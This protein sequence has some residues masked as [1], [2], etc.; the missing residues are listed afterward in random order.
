MNRVLYSLFLSLNLKEN[1][2][3]FIFQTKNKY[4]RNNE[5]K[6]LCKNYYLF[7]KVYY[8]ILKYG[9]KF[10]TLKKISNNLNAFTKT[11]CTYWL[12][13]A[14]VSISI[15]CTSFIFSLLFNSKEKHLN[16][17]KF[18][19]ILREYI[20]NNKVKKKK[21]YKNSFSKIIIQY[22]IQDISVPS[23][24]K[25]IF[26]IS[27]YKF[28]L[29]YTNTNSLYLRKFLPNN[30][31]A[32]TGKTEWEGRVSPANLTSKCF[33][34][35]G[36]G[37]KGSSQSL[38]TSARLQ[39]VLNSFMARAARNV[40]PGPFLSIYLAPPILP[41]IFSALDF[42]ARLA[43]IRSYD[44][45]CLSA[46]RDNGTVV[47]RTRREKRWRCEQRCEREEWKDRV[48]DRER[49]RHMCRLV[50]QIRDNETSLP[51]SRGNFPSW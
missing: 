28:T 43:S 30:L 6:K 46:T 51:L 4:I 44:I 33:F 12:F 29:P 34:E 25:L 38:E 15:P 1:L 23:I 27:L 20:T 9:T 8:S 32:I 7:S 41:A 10:N 40:I 50:A 16:S 17:L 45:S 5:D 39:W 35:K 18:L 3:S 19:Q 2:N 47:T 37:R 36:A 14:W 48:R 49:E 31:N 22:N 26:Q 11:I 24:M 21:L 42:V 13:Y